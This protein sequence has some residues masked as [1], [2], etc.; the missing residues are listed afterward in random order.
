M[1][2][3]LEFYH[4]SSFPPELR[5]DAFI[6]FHGS[7]NRDVPTG[8]KV[9]RL[10]FSDGAPQEVEPFFEYGGD[11]DISEDWPHRPVDVAEGR[12][13]ELYVTSDASGVIIV[14]GHER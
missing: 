5:G 13:G 2:L 3:G 6:G 9:V 8:Y 11:G 10:R 1:R 14:I 7:W 4:G 12:D